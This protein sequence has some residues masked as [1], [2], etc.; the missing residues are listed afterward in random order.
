[1]QM[2]KQR[3]LLLLSFVTIFVMYLLA[4][5]HYRS[6]RDFKSYKSDYVTVVSMY[7]TLNKSKHSQ[8]DYENWIKSFMVSVDSPKVIICDIKSQKLLQRYHGTSKVVYYVYENIWHIMRLLEKYRGMKYIDNY[9]TKQQRLDR[10]SR[11]HNPDLYAIWNLKSF[12]LKFVSDDNPFGSSYFIYTDVGAWRQGI[13]DNWPDEDF[14]KKLMEVQKDRVLFAQISDDLSD[15]EVNDIIQGGIIAGNKKSIDSL[16]KNY[17]SIHDE[18][19]RKDRFVGKDQ[20]LMNYLAFRYF[21]STT[22]KLRTWK[23]TCSKSYDR[24][25]FYQ[26]FFAKQHNYFCRNNRFS[27]LN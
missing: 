1:M 10:E 4:K 13:I 27:I 22:I 11:I 20:I 3:I 26:Y 9:F 7:F 8:N 5:Y 25:F 17:Y 19:V 6:P 21:N 15:F 14:I 16:F 23:L 2:R 24:W 18:R 12:I